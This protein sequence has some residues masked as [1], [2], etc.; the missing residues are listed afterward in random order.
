MMQLVGYGV[1]MANA[2]PALHAVA[3]YVT[4]LNNANGVATGIQAIMA[5]YL[6]SKNSLE[7]VVY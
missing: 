7:S 4:G 3:K 2:K 6:V 1:A 5:A